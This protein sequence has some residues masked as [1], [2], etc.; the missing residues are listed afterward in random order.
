MKIK[1]R[2]VCCECARS[3][4]FSVTGVTDKSVVRIDVSVHG[5]SDVNVHCSGCVGLGTPQ[6]GKVLLSRKLKKNLIGLK[7]KL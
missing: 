5:A 2:C 7:S 6:V 4:Y 3:L 1:R